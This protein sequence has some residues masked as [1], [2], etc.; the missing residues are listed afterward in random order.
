MHTKSG[1]KTTI[2]VRIILSFFFF[3]EVADHILNCGINYSSY[4][5][6]TR[7]MWRTL[8]K[9]R[10]PVSALLVETSSLRRKTISQVFLIFMT[11][12]RQNIRLF[13]KKFGLT[14]NLDSGNN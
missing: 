7:E 10:N 5:L 14:N 4:V 1:E 8:K 2:C 11:Y 9:K 3:F 13:Q 12:S 6:R